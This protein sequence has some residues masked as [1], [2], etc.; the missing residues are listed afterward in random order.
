[1]NRIGSSLFV[2]VLQDGPDQR[3]PIARKHVGVTRGHDLPK[4]LIA[5]RRVPLVVTIKHAGGHVVPIHPTRHAV[6]AADLGRRVARPALPRF[7][8]DLL[9]R[10]S[11]FS[12]APHGVASS[13]D[14][15]ECKD[16][17]SPRPAI[18]YADNSAAGR[19]LAMR[20]PP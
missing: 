3:W 18:A 15:V 11:H 9:F 2:V 19:A 20:L 14:P 5:H 1:M 8:N 7:I 13:I 17:S 6:S 4:H 10:V 16:R 12:R